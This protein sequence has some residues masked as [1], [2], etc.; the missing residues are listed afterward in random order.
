MPCSDHRSLHRACI[1]LMKV[2]SGSASELMAS[3]KG[4]NRKNWRSTPPPTAPSP[5][6]PSGSPTRFLPL[7]PPKAPAPA[8]DEPRTFVSLHRAPP[9]PHPPDPAAP[10][11]V[12]APHLRPADEGRQ[13]ECERAHGKLE[14]EEQEE[15][16][17][18]VVVQE[19]VELQDQACDRCG[20]V[21]ASGLPRA[22]GLEGGQ[23]VDVSVNCRRAVCAA[24]RDRTLA[25]RPVGPNLSVCACVRAR[26]HA[27]TD[28][29]SPTHPEY[30]K[31]PAH[32]K[33]RSGGQR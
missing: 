29:P 9:R 11:Q 17:A 19:Q 6:Q 23:M 16:E 25:C 24:C 10:P 27:Q 4:K 7:Y 33:C 22:T 26:T 12:P 28:W 2:D 15:Q 3:W 32:R 13:Q 21:Q 5:T 31:I 18:V 8:C 30:K 14:Q 1:L 20:C